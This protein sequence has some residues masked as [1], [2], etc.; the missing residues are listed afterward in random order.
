MI[1]LQQLP[2][3]GKKLCFWMAKICLKPFFYT[4]LS[5]IIYLCSLFLTG[6]TTAYIQLL[7][8]WLLSICIYC[9]VWRKGFY[10]KHK[11]HLNFSCHL[12]FKHSAKYAMLNIYTY[13]HTGGLIRGSDF[14]KYLYWIS[15][16]GFK[17]ICLLGWPP[18]I[19]GGGIWQT[20]LGVTRPWQS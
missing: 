8:Y 15:R 16:G 14:Y 13:I 18:G 9:I 4:N 20:L 2:L 3:T 7:N 6:I 10:A 1:T 19:G 12:L 17:A 11:N 5:S